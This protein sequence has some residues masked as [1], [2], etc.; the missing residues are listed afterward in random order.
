MILKLE[1][2]LRFALFCHVGAMFRN[3][4]KP[5]S[6]FARNGPKPPEVDPFVNMQHG[7][8]DVAALKRAG[9]EQ[10]RI[11]RNV[12]GGGTLSGLRVRIKTLPFVFRSQKS[13]PREVRE[14][15]LAFNRFR[16]FLF[17]FFACSAFLSFPFLFW[18]LLLPFFLLFLLVPFVFGNKLSFQKTPQ[19]MCII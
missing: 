17:L 12:E 5:R 18:C 4:K 16:F 3:G 1:M 15:T 19:N 2:S 11:E 10:L 9:S 7:M 14:A 8:R 13:T 6:K